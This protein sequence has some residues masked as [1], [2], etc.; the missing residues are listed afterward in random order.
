[1]NKTYR[2][3]FPENN[4]KVVYI[5]AVLMDNRE[6]MHYGKSLGFVTEEQFKMVQDDACKLTKGNEPIVAIKPKVA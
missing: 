5:E 2:A 4:M 6:L 1:M 3:T